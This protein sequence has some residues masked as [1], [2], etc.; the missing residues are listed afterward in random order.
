MRKVALK[1]GIRAVIVNKALDRL[2][3]VMSNVIRSFSI[4]HLQDFSC[5][6]FSSQDFSISDFSSQDFS[7]QDFSCQDF[8]CQDISCL[9][10]SNWDFFHCS[11]KRTLWKG[12]TK[13]RKIYLEKN[14][15]LI[16]EIS[17][18]SIRRRGKQEIGIRRDS[19][20]PGLGSK[21]CRRI[22]VSDS[23]KLF[24]QKYCRK[25]KTCIFNSINKML[26]DFLHC[27]GK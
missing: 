25:R 4:F 12:T 19:E 7:C 6:D 2:V 22:L 17:L 14:R 18:D 26:G 27:I 8:S 21:R 16:R 11:L 15:A 10:F 1:I 9:D 5:Q 24:L 20:F 23:K 13:F 3:R